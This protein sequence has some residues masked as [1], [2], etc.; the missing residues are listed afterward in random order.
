MQ[1]SGRI[2]YRECELAILSDGGLGLV[3]SLLQSPLGKVSGT[4]C[5]G[6]RA[7]GSS[8]CTAVVSSK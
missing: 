3:T 6:H 5:A 2:G 4:S 8:G 7:G 1:R